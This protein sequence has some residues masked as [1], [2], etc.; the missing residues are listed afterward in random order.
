LDS[1]ASLP[2]G[3][4]EAIEKLEQLRAIEHGFRIK[5]VETTYDSKEV[6]RPEDV[7]KLEAVLG[8]RHNSS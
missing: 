1:F 2:Q 6:D 4:L 5:V 7:H 3:R 8:T